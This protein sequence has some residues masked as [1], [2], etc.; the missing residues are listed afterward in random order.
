MVFVC[1]VNAYVAEQEGLSLLLRMLAWMVLC[2]GRKMHSRA[3]S[4]KSLAL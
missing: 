2:K 3:T 1:D 4:E